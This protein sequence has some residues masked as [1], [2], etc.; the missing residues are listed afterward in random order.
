MNLTVPT[1]PLN[2][3]DI[4]HTKRYT[5]KLYRNSRIKYAQ[6]MNNTHA[7]HASN[8]RDK[9][10]WN[11]NKVALIEIIEIDI[12]EQPSRFYADLAVPG[13]RLNIIVVSISYFLCKWVH[14]NISLQLS[15]L[16][17]F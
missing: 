1:L 9:I 15:P 6:I 3:Y 5:L 16:L 12:G 17:A 13:L 7:A 10:I 4:I 8:G 2:F 11:A 14:L